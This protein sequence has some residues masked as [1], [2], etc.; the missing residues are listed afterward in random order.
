MAQ[1]GREALQAYRVVVLTLAAVWVEETQRY[2]LGWSDERVAV[3]TGQPRD[4]VAVAR[5]G[6]F[7]PNPEAGVL[8]RIRQAILLIAQ[9]F[10]HLIETGARDKLAR[11]VGEAE[12]DRRIR[13]GSAPTSGM[14]EADWSDD[15]VAEIVGLEAG[16]VRELREALPW[17]PPENRPEARRQRLAASIGTGTRAG[18]VLRLSEEVDPST[19][20]PYDADA[21]L[22]L[23]IDAGEVDPRTESARRRELDWIDSTIAVGRARIDSEGRERSPVQIAAMIGIKHPEKVRKILERFLGTVNASEGRPTRLT[24]AVCQRLELADP[25]G[26]D[27]KRSILSWAVES[28]WTTG[29]RPNWRTLKGWR[30]RGVADIAAGRETLPARFERAIVSIIARRTEAT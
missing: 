21:L 14:W 30:A 9:H 23:L 2:L 26:I 6:G 11:E 1:A 17:V 3:V 18:R 5:E 15:R 12:L 25:L 27:P 28:V 29:D 16:Q 19:G 20:K 4:M 8:W 10:D 22:R 24:A 7:G 13:T